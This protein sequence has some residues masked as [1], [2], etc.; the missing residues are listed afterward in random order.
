MISGRPHHG[1]PPAFSLGGNMSE[2]D[3]E[4]LIT[5]TDTASQA[6]DDLFPPLPSASEQL[7]QYEERLK[8]PE[9]SRAEAEWFC[10]TCKMALGNITA[11]EVYGQKPNHQI[12]VFA[13]E[14]A[15]SHLARKR[16]PQ[17]NAQLV[18]YTVAKLGKLL[19]DQ[20]ALLEE[21]KQVD[22]ENRRLKRQ[23]ET[24]TREVQ[25]VTRT[26]NAILADTKY[27]HPD[28]GKI[29]KESETVSAGIIGR[30]RIGW[31]GQVFAL[32]ESGL[33]QLCRSLRITSAIATVSA[34]QS[35]EVATLRKEIERLK[36]QLG[37]QATPSSARRTMR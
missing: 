23:V 32:N 22:E 1:V 33:G 21:G 17:C 6:A 18:E 24:L 19:W 34:G 25:E 28:S 13:S 14:I 16:C 35:T 12:N 4:N 2:N 37:S 7:Q 3:T 9:H 27:F 30:V 29:I 20:M 11:T 31:D 10:P 5:T 36:L 8:H 15:K 26:A